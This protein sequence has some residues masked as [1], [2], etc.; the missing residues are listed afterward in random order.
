MV[1]RRN[2]IIFQNWSVHSLFIYLFIYLLLACLLAA[3]GLRCC[4]QAFSSRREWGLLFTAVYGPLIAVASLVAEH[5][6]QAHGFQ[7]LWHMGSVAAARGLWVQAQ[8]LWRKG[9]LVALWHV[10]SSQT[11]ARTRVPCIGR[12]ILKPLRHQGG[13]PFTIF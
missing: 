7:K 10:G 8:Q 11:R 2:F 12:Q 6:V 1:E 4:T 3:L 13:P 5:E 9:L